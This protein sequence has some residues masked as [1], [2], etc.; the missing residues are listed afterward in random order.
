MYIWD[1][2]WYMTVYW[3]TSLLPK[4][5]FYIL[6]FNNVFHA[7]MCY[8]CIWLR[9]MVLQ[10]CCKGLRVDQWNSK[11]FSCFY[12]RSRTS[13]VGKVRNDY[14]I[15]RSQVRI[16]TRPSEHK[17]CLCMLD[18]ALYLRLSWI[19]NHLLVPRLLKYGTWRL[20]NMLHTL[21]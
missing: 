9:W 18:K 10:V 7:T 16:S 8:F 21:V 4:L 19:I 6:T 2:L 17:I 5:I 12:D 11:I 3:S 15:R 20:S 13:S 14:E 1:I